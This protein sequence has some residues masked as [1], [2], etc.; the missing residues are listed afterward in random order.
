[1]GGCYRVIGVRLRDG[2]GGDLRGVLSIRRGVEVMGRVDGRNLGVQRVIGG[3]W[4]E[5]GGSIEIIWIAM[6]RWRGA[7]RRSEEI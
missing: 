5:Y 2:H 7:L 1:M 6:E 4:M 3:L